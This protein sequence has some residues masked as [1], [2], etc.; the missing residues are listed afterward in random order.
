MSCVPADPCHGPDGRRL[1]LSLR[2]DAPSWLH[3]EWMVVVLEPAN[4]ASLSMDLMLPMLALVGVVAPC[5]S[6]MS[7][8]VYARLPKVRHF[9]AHFPPF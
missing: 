9:P 5:R 2:Q 6:K 7:A 1:T 4:A 8:D 3:S